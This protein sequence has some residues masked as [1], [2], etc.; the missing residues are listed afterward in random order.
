MVPLKFYNFTNL[1]NVIK[2]L[3]LLSLMLA[4]TDDF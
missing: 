4:V 1:L 3:F 2:N